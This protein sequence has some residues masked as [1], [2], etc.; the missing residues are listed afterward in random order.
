[1]ALALAGSATGNL[2]KL[3]SE[4]M[5]AAER[6]QLRRLLSTF[7]RRL[8]PSSRCCDIDHRFDLCPIRWTLTQTK[9]RTVAVHRRWYRSLWA[10]TTLAVERTT[11]LL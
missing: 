2:T 9:C 10:S 1:M 7:F 4:R 3:A 6:S 5:Q 11:D 8:Q